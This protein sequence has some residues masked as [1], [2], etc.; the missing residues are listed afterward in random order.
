MAPKP[1]AIIGVGNY[2][3]GDEGVGIHAIARLEAEPW[4]EG[5]ELIDG[6]TPGLALMYLLEGRELVILIDCADFGAEP[7]A[8]EAFDPE[9]LARDERAEISL[10][11]TDL[12]SSLALAKQ[13]GDAYPKRV[14]I[15]GI[16]PKTIAMGTALSPEAE[17]ALEHLP[18]F[19]R[20]RLQKR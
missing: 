12:L 19:L 10:H 11:A 1:I 13:L 18:A 15:V 14:R 7:G 9:E 8:I 17:A 5:V 6:G 2:L 20:D 3:M 16:Q 4:P